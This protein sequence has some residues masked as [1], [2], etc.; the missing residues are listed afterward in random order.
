MA[1]LRV[2]TLPFVLIS[3]KND[4]NQVNIGYPIEDIMIS[5]YVE[6]ILPRRMSTTACSFASRFGQEMAQNVDLPT[7]CKNFSGMTPPNFRPVIGDRAVLFPD[8]C[9]F[10]SHNFQIVPARLRLADTLN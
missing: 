7:S 6:K 3:S 5:E 9:C 2:T 8:S 4:H 10:G 1:A